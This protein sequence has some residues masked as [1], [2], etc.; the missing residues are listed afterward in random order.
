[1]ENQIKTSKIDHHFSLIS[2]QV[3]RIVVDLKGFHSSLRCGG[4]NHDTQV[5]PSK[6]YTDLVLYSYD[7]LIRLGF[8]VNFSGKSG[9]VSYVIFP[10]FCKHVR[11]AVGWF[12]DRIELSVGFLCFGGIRYRTTG[13]K[14]HESWPFNRKWFPQS[15]IAMGSSKCPKQKELFLPS[16]G[17]TAHKMPPASCHD[18]STSRS[19]GKS[20]GQFMPFMKIS[21]WINYKVIKSNIK[22][23]ISPFSLL[24]HL[25]LNILNSHIFYISMNHKVSRNLT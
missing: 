11:N 19:I 1:M 14:G 21:L 6:N 3:S 15:S 10:H 25:Q 13:T 18:D 16:W 12:A 2:L 17:Q 4:K 8:L 5:P 24:E 7:L 20:L 23:N 22:K 9:K